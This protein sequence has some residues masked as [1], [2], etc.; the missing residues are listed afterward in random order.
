M[1]HTKLGLHNYIESENKETDAWFSIDKKRILYLLF[2]LF[3]I[4]TFFFGW[5]NEQHLENMK[6]TIISL[7]I[8]DNGT[9]D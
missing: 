5:N 3:K 1:I 6:S 7:K 9:K 4:F 8:S 2:I